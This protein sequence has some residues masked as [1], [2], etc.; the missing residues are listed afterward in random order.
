MNEDRSLSK[1]RKLFTNSDSNINLFTSSTDIG[2]RRNGGRN[3]AR[4]APIV[5]IEQFK[6][7]IFHLRDIEF[8]EFE[9]SNRQKEEKD[10]EL[11]QKAEIKNI[12]QKL[13][14]QNLIHIGG[15]HDHIYPLLMAL[16]KKFKNIY[17]LNIDAHCD[18]RNEEVSHSGTPFRDFDKNKNK[19]TNFKLI[20][21][22][23]HLFANSPSTL[24]DLQNSSMQIINDPQDTTTLFNVL[25]KVNFKDSAFVLSLDCDGLS[26]DIMK[27]VSAVNHFGTSAQT[28]NAIID[29]VKLID[30]KHKSFGIYE[31]NP[32]FEDLSLSGARFIAHLLYK[33]SFTD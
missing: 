13:N 16:E 15:G 11:A 12:G 5:I 10:F 2:V 25:D 27:A 31:Y 30:A 23:V 3:G 29:R 6:N 17:V 8:S 4:F 1:I 24:K 20:Q 14:D 33:F 18:T 32:I 9:I 22:G 21:F 28:M 26:S 19:K 7:M